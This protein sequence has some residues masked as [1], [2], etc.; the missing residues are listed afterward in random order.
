MWI[1]CKIWAVRLLTP[2]SGISLCLAKDEGI[3]KKIIHFTALMMITLG[4]LGSPP[5]V[6]SPICHD[7]S[8]RTADTQWEFWLELHMQLLWFGIME[9]NSE[10]GQEIWGLYRS[11]KLHFP[12]V[13][14]EKA[15]TISQFCRVFFFQ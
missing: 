2:W 4:T 5:P 9:V 10:W 14:R 15:S 7:F 8:S 13:R 3:K 1:L 6:A 12:C 11:D